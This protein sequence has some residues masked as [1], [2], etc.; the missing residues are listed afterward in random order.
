MHGAAPVELAVHLEDAGV[1]GEVAASAVVWREAGVEG[2]GGDVVGDG[3]D[4]GER[5]VGMRQKGKK[6]FCVEGRL[7]HAWLISQSVGSSIA[8]RALQARGGTVALA[9][10]LLGSA[11]WAQGLE[12][13]SL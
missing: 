2:W 9:V 7:L 4:G 8:V 13:T 1:G 10:H 12:A 6:Q 3:E 11:Q 5:D